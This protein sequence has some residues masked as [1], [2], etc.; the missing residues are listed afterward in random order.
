[1]FAW[2]NSTSSDPLS[3]FQYVA[4][5]EPIFMPVVLFIVW[6]VI[7]LSTLRFGFARAWLFA[8]FTAMVL[9]AVGAVAG[10]IAVK[11]VILLI[12]M[13]ALGAFFIK[14]TNSAE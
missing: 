14:I 7:A 6:A 8:S 13:T 5:A 9:S 3:F 1:M 2:Y 12:L 10:L 11:Y 4:G